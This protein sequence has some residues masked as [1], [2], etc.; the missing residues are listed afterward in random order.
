M[1]AFVER[2]VQKITEVAPLEDAVSGIVAGVLENTAN[3]IA[4]GESGDGRQAFESEAA[5][6]PAGQA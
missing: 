3:K 4:R 1:T 2:L 6:L 5:E